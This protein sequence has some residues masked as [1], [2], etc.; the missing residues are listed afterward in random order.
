MTELKYVGEIDYSQIIIEKELGAGG[1][2]SV[3]LVK[4]RGMT[5]AMKQLKLT[6]CDNSKKKKLVSSLKLE[7]EALSKLGQC[8]YIIQFIGTCI[9]SGNTMC[10]LMEYINGRDLAKFIEKDCDIFNWDLRQRVTIEIAL[11]MNFIHSKGI[12]HRDIKSDNILIDCSGEMYR[13]KIADFGICR[14]EKEDFEAEKTMT[15]MGAGSPCWMAPELFNKIGIEPTKKT[16]IYALG[17]VMWEICALKRPFQNMD[18]HQ[19]GINK[20]NGTI[21]EVPSS[22]PQNYKELMMRC[23]HPD[24]I[25][26]PFADEV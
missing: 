13:A 22:T 10:M 25:I 1:F 20:L 15:F 18:H 7:A 9:G 12:I 21:E 2:G 26:R 19:I 17:V 4:Y 8:P 16:D 23:Q 14:V 6:H 24:P 11:G 3:H 5:C